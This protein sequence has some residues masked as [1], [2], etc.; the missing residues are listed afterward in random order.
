MDSIDCLI[1]GAGPA[2]LTAAVYLA[3]YRRSVTLVDSGNSRA[4][5]IPLSRNLPGY[6]QGIAGEELLQRLYAQ[7][8]EYQLQITHDHVQELRRD[9]GEGFYARLASGTT[10]HARSV[11]L[12]TGVVDKEIAMDDWAAA[13]KCGCIRLCPICDAF[14]VVGKDI[15]LIVGSKS[16]TQHALFMQTYTDKLTLIRHY[17]ALPL[18]DDEREQLSQ[19]GV[20][21][22]EAAA[23]GI[24]FTA[25]MR[26]VVQ[27]DNGTSCEFDVVYPMLGEKP[28]VELATSLGA[29]CDA[30]GALLVDSKQ[31]TSIAGLYAAGDVVNTLNQ[32]SVAY[33]HAAIAATAIH[34]SLRT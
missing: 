5:L 22:L 6:P 30:D 20:A 9:D 18:T 29:N 26:P 28:G 8:A 21:L 14:E 19:A 24:N 31:C 16:C 4:R 13:V 17:Q 33:G 10:L 3:R 32:I 11:L 23:T 2:G 27:L 25:E 12:A 34:N 15:A 7:I 1:V